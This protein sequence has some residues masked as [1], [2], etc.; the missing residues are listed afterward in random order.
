MAPPE[1]FRDIA[2]RVAV[3][4]ALFLSTIDLVGATFLKFF[5]ISLPV[6]Q[7]A[8]G[9]VLAAMGWKLLNREQAAPGN[10]VPPAQARLGSLRERVFYPFTFPITVGPGCIAVTLTLSA[11]ASRKDYIPTAFAQG[12]IIAAI[13]LLSL[14]VYLSY[15]YAQVI[16]RKVSRQTV[17][18]ILRVIAFVLLCIGAQIAWNGLEELIRRVQ[19]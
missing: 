1:V 7:V 16:T 11:H 9:F 2:R 10:P 4:T 18:G 6:V 14:A 8:G 3:T 5:D 12:G 15:A 17:H 13:L 19:R